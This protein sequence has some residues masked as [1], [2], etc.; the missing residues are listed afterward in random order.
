MYLS[1]L[2]FKYLIFYVFIKFVSYLI[3]SIHFKYNCQLFFSIQKPFAETWSI[4]CLSRFHTSYILDLL[5]D[6]HHFCAFMQF[7]FAFVSRNAHMMSIKQLF[8]SILLT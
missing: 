1:N 2:Y 3:I 8:I 4:K 5:H 6:F 7:V